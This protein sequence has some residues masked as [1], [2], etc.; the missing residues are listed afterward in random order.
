[1]AINGGYQVGYKIKSP[2]AAVWSCSILFS[3]KATLE[4]KQA[5]GYKAFFILNSAEH[6]S[7]LAHKC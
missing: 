4:L 3:I 7:Y 5:R 2:M 6:E 1:M